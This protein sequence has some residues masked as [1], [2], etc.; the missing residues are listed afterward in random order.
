MVAGRRRCT[1]VDLYVWLSRPASTLGRMAGMASVPKQGTMATVLQAYQFAL[2]PTPCKQGS[3]ASHTGAARF[4]YNWGV[5]V[6][7]ARLDQ[8]RAGEDVQVPWTL[9]ELR[10]EWNRAK[11]QVAPWWQENSKEAYNSGL[12]ALARALRNWNDSRSGRRKGRPVGFPRRKKK[13]RARVACRFTTGQIKVLADRKHIQLPR[14]GVVKTH[15]STRKLARRLEQG[16][17]RVLAATISRKA[18]RWFVAFTCEVQRAVP[19][20]DGRPSVVGVDVGVRH[21]AVLSTGQTVPNPRALEGSRR[22]LRRLNRELARRTPGSRRTNRTRRRL[23][24]TYARTANLR[25][26]SLHKLTTTLA[27]EHGTVVVE[28]LNV[29]GMVRNRRLARAIAD[30]GMAELRRLLSYKTTWYGCRLVVAD[31]FFPSSK[32]CSAC[33]WVKAKLTL[34]DRTFHCE[35]CGLV[36]DRDLNAACNL[37]KL[38][39]WIAAAGSGPE[40]LNARGA[41]RKPQLAGQVALKREAGTGSY[42]KETGTVQP[43]GWTT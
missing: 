35:A 42:L 37:T 43:Q 3:L 20:G 29:A 8:R 27:T 22:K 1:A 39:D 33:G 6:V 19:A 16:T 34:A 5:E 23:A 25:R 10:R 9:V 2:D 21:L 28:H 18:D 15:E 31:R 11:H 7:T 32:T 12:D 13:H 36:L 14:I 4:A 17:A 30:T 24:R 40:A 38:V 26:D 41:D